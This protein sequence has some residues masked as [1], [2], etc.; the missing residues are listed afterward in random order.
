[1]KKS[2][3]K[4]LRVYRITTEKFKK[5]Y[6]SDKIASC[7]TTKQVHV[8]TDLLLG[9][10]KAKILPDNIEKNYSQINSQTIS[11]S[12]LKISENI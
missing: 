10:K 3:K 7:S 6:N 12:R 4:E 2:T 5:Q 11:F 8:T 9:N 1:M